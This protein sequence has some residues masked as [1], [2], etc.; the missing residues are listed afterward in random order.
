MTGFFLNFD[1]T[2]TDVIKKLLGKSLT[3]LVG[4][5]VLVVGKVLIISLIPLTP[6]V[7]K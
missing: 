4:N 3:P 6:M 2:G 1:H 7:E 5:V